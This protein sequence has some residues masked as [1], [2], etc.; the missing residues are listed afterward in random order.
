MACA[1]PRSPTSWAATRRPC[2]SGCTGS[3]PRAS[4]GSATGQVPA[5]SAPPGRLHQGGEGVLAPDQP[6]A[7]T[8]WTLD[9]LAE[10]AQAEGIR[11]GRFPVRFLFAWLAVAR[12]EEHT[13][14]LQS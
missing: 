11:V 12:S 5:R 3:T 9:A 4:T 13:S 2:G 7:P 6:Q 14:E 1:P 8:H 10:R